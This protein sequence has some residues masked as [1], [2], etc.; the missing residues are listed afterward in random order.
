MKLSSN[1]GLLVALSP[2]VRLHVSA[3]TN[4][5]SDLP[6]TVEDIVGPNA[7]AP[8]GSCLGAYSFTLEYEGN[9]K[10]DQVRERIESYLKNAATSCDHDVDAE[11]KILLGVESEKDV[12]DTIEALCRDAWENHNSDGYPWADVTGYGAA[13]DKEYY[14]GNTVS[15]LI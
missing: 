5:I 15:N 2:T 9:C 13:W 12:E 1:L 8:S 3:K 7:N 10:Y 14:D 6:I 11:L 4:S